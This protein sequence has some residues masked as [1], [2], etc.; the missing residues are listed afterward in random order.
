M[1]KYLFRFSSS[2][3]SGSGIGMLVAL[4]SYESESLLHAWNEAIDD[5]DIP[6]DLLEVIRLKSISIA[7]VGELEECVACGAN[8]NE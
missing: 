2:E 8:R 4:K 1:K 7:Y 3:Y 6:P 5:A